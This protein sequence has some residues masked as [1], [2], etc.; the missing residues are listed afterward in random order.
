M[1]VTESSIGI[2]SEIDRL[3]A[4]AMLH[5]QDLEGIVTVNLH[6]LADHPR[7]TVMGR[8]ATRVRLLLGR[9]TAIILLLLFRHQLVLQAQLHSRPPFRAVLIR[10]LLHQLALG[11]VA[12]VASGTMH[13]AISLAHRRAEDQHIGVGEVE[14]F[15]EAH[16]LDL[17]DQPVGQHRSLPLSVVQATA[18]PL[19]ILGHSVSV[20]I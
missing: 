10:Y 19:L 8:V 6:H 15:T 16:L 12:V 11:V 9:R 5:Q 20:I 4:I 1:I 2:A 7:L 17:V 3:L 18:L 14:A 13:L